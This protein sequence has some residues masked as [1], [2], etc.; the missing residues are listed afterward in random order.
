[1]AGIRGMGSLHDGILRHWTQQRDTFLSRTS[2]VRDDGEQAHRRALATE[3]PLTSRKEPLASRV[4]RPLPF[5][6]PFTAF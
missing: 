6:H 1:M 3:F 5:R 4:S 2:F